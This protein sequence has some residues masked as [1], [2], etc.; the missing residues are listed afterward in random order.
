M[1]TT[2]VASKSQSARW[3]ATTTSIPPRVLPT[4]IPSYNLRTCSNYTSAIRRHHQPFHV[5][6]ASRYAWHFTAYLS[7]DVHYDSATIPHRALLPI[8]PCP[9]LLSGYANTVSSRTTNNVLLCT[10][11]NPIRLFYIYRHYFD[12][13]YDY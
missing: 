13:E 9:W 5:C 12:F 2:P 4:S 3:S 11:H 8:S 1:D 6:H 7:Y 10:S